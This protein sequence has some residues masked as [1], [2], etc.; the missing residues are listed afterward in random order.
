MTWFKVDD[1]FHSHAKTLKAGN[2]ALGLWV[3]CGSH[4][5]QHL[6]DGFVPR[7]IALLYGTT[8]LAARLVEAGLWRPVDGGWAM[9]DYHDYNPSAEKVQAERHAATQRQR[10]A[11]EAAKS[12]RVSRRDNRVS[13]GPPDPTRPDPT[14]KPP[15]GA[16][17]DESPDR[18]RDNL[19]P[20]FPSIPDP[21]QGPA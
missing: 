20:Q 13:H 8:A 9:H 10:S 4:C 19:P 14:P 16:A 21:P 1:S 12:R 17:G 5:A 11:R 18:A 15:P 3:R 2:A 7:E 6:T